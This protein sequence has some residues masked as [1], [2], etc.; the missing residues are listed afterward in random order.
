[1][2]M[3]VSGFGGSRPAQLAGNHL[4]YRGLDRVAE[5]GEMPD[6]AHR[7]VAL[8]PAVE[9]VGAEILEEGAVAEHV[10]GGGQDGRRDRAD[11]LLRAAPG[12]QALE[13]RPEIAVLLSAGG[14]GALDEGGLEPAP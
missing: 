3:M 1:M 8:G 6:E 10:A 7:P 12:A 11:R 4:L 2:P 14:P 13:L 9:V 5:G